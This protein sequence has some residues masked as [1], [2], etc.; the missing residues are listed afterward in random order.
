MMPPRKEETD[1]GIDLVRI[2][3]P[4][5]VMLP[6]GSST[7]QIGNRQSYSDGAG[8]VVEGVVKRMRLLPSLLIEV[9]VEASDGQVGKVV[10]L[11]SGMIGQCK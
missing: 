1:D 6:N 10:L 11:P 5:N 8:N 9:A 4:A 2:V 3:L 7:L